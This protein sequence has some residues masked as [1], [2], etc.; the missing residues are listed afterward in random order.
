MSLTTADTTFSNYIAYHKSD[1]QKK[2][3]LKKVFLGFSIP[4]PIPIS[5]LNFIF[6]VPLSKI[7][8]FRVNYLPLSA[9]R[10]SK[11]PITKRDFKNR[12]KKSF[13][14]IPIKV[15]K[16]RLGTYPKSTKRVLFTYLAFLSF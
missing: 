6:K 10:Y 4:I 7:R 14:G 9:F 2:K 12:F 1:L 13:L 8:C 15:F 3:S 5:V 11:V 16:V